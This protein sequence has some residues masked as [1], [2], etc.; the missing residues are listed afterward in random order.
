MIKYIFFVFSLFCLSCSSDN[1]IHSEKIDFYNIY[2]DIIVRAPVNS[3]ADEKIEKK[4]YNR[5]W[6]SEFNQPI[7][8]LSSLDGKN[9]ATLVLLGNYQNKLTWVSSDG[10]S[11]SFEDGILIATRGYSQD[12]IEA[13]HNNLDKLFTQAISN[14]YKTYRFL[15]GKNQYEELKFLCSMTSEQNTDSKVLNLTLKTTKFTEFCKSDDTRHSNEFYVLPNTN[16]VI[17]SKQWISKANGYVI[18]YNYYAFQNNL[19]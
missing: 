10:I 12:L 19:L 6:L 16:I 4:V 14:R 11:L 9:D 8:L 17:K 15:N 18:I 2:K 5:E 7:I 13:Q 3:P 1:I